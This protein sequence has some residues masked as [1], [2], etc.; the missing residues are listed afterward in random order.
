[1]EK[2]CCIC[3]KTFIEYANNASPIKNGVCC[4]YCNIKY[5]I[6]GRLIV[7]SA[8]SGV[9][10]EI[11]KTKK[12]LDDLEEKLCKKNFWKMQSGS[13][14]SIY[15]NPESEEKVVVCII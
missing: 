14:L 10:F 3:G 1:M 7:A 9:N 12:Q 2:R 6:P 13:H 15:Q 11:V 8:Y 4:D 5:I